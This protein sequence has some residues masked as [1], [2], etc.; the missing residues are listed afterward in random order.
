MK[1]LWLMVLLMLAG[2]RVIGLLAVHPIS[3]GPIE[4]DPSTIES[5]GISLP[6]LG[7]DEDYD[8]VA[9]VSYREL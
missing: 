6:V 1:M 9:R 2:C 4:F 8:A 7:G 3:V 5:V